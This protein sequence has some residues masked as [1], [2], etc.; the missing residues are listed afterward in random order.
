MSSSPDFISKL[1]QSA[2][3]KVNEF[4][5]EAA[6][7]TVSSLSTKT[8]ASMNFI[9]NRPFFFYIRDNVTGMKLFMGKVVSP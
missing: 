3:I 9:C 4:G 7:V 8:S 2:F 1:Q 6:A 5:L